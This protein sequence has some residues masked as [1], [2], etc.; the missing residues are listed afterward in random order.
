VVGG[1][2]GGDGGGGAAAG[3]S[4]VVGKV[5]FKAVLQLQ[6]CRAGHSQ[7]FNWSLVFALL[8]LLPLGCCLWGIWT[9]ALGKVS[10]AASHR[11]GEEI[12]ADNGWECL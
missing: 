11:A 2:C 6:V 8:C 3:A 5:A 9:D 7:R 12:K 4:D 10:I 1:G